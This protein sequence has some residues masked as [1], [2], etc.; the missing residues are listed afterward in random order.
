M[1]DELRTCVFYSFGESSVLLSP[2]PATYEE[3][4][5]NIQSLQHQ[6]KILNIELETY[7]LLEVEFETLK[8]VTVCNEKCSDIHVGTSNKKPV[9]NCSNCNKL[10]S[11]LKKAKE[12]ILSFKEIIKMLQDEESEIVQ[13]IGDHEQNNYIGEQSIAPRMEEDWVLVPTKNN[14]K[15]EDLNSNLIQII[16]TSENYYDFFHNLKEKEEVTNKIT[17]DFNSPNTNNKSQF[18]KRAKTVESQKNF[19][20]KVCILGDSRMR[21]CATELRQTLGCR[22]A[23]TGFTKPGAPTTDL[24]KTVEE[25]ISTFTTKDFVILWTGAN[26]ISKNNT[27]GALSSLSKFME[28]N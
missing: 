13:Q 16:P 19:K 28:E 17:K 6:N 1:A 27:N 20:H 15:L 12:E 8:T 24:I 4:Q 14:R 26:D 22:F 5:K 11:A 10:N 7:K 25:E 23:V 9:S 21:K 2:S 18:K 3:L